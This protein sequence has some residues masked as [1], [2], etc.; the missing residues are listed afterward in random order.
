MCPKCGSQHHGWA[1]MNPRHQT[2]PRCGT[3]LKVSVNGQAFEGYSPF[4]AEILVAK[5]QEE[6]LTVLPPHQEK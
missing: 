3:G 1:L 2:C 5:K 6:T 4:N